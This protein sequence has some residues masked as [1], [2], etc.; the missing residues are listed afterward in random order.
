MGVHLERIVGELAVRVHARPAVDAR[1]RFVAN[2]PA[3]QVANLGAFHVK[4]VSREVERETA[5][6]HGPAE[7]ADPVFRFDQHVG[8]AVEMIGRAQAGETR[9]D[10]QDGIAETGLQGFR[11]HR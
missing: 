1:E 2:E 8:P 7:A 10:D 5:G 9:A 11:L 3:D 6:A 4:K